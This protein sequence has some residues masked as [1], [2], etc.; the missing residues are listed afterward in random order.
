MNEGAP[1]ELLGYFVTVWSP[2]AVARRI[3]HPQRRYKYFYFTQVKVPV[4]VL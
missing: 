4:T 3:Q 2:S 1:F